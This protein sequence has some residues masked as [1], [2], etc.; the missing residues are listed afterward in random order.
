VTGLYGSERACHFLREPDVSGAPLDGKERVDKAAQHTT[1]NYADSAPVVAL[2]QRGSSVCEGTYWGRN[3]SVGRPIRMGEKVRGCAQ[4]NTRL[5]FY[6]VAF[7]GQARPLA[8]GFEQLACG[9]YPS[10]FEFGNYGI[11]LCKECAG[12]LAFPEHSKP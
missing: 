3:L 10:T 7:S 5:T 1:A 9:Y 6:H 11:L 12:R 4:C 8:S 2:A